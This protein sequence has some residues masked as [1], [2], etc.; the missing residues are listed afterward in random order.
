MNVNVS[1]VLNCVSWIYP[2]CRYSGFIFWPQGVNCLTPLISVLPAP[3]GQC[4]RL[5]KAEQKDMIFMCAMTGV[6]HQSFRNFFVCLG[7][8]TPRYVGPQLR[9]G[10]GLNFWHFKLGFFY[11][12]GSPMIEARK[13]DFSL[14]ILKP[15]H[16]CTLTR[17]QL[18]L[19][20]TLYML[21]VCTGIPCTW[22]CNSCPE[23][24]A[25]GLTFWFYASISC[26]RHFIISLDTMV[27]TSN[28]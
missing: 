20:V 9:L 17:T 3:Q 10:L 4:R 7:I 15:V 8:L 21:I 23:Q 28:C 1:M 26:Q 24:C 18:I 5:I 22:Q 27:S 16:S 11:V 25:V 14:S 13:K 2:Q 6:L 12:L 19:T